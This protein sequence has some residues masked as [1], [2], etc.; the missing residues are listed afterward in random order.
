M[1]WSG[2]SFTSPTRGYG[3]VR[4]SYV[5]T[6]V[7]IIGEVGNDSGQYQGVIV[8]REGC[9]ASKGRKET[10]SLAELLEIA[11]NEHTNKEGH[12][13]SRDKHEGPWTAG[14]GGYRDP[15][16]FDP[17]GMGGE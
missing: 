9:K 15:E 5:V 3:E 7:T 4:G 17:T 11:R 2:W 14:P 10:G 1:S 8:S 13:I 6:E 12:V 16:G